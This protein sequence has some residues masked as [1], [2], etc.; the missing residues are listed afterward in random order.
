[1]R[2][3]GS[4]TLVAMVIDGLDLIMVEAYF[5]VSLASVAVV[6]AFDAVSGNVRWWR[7]RAVVAF[8]VARN[9]RWWGSQGVI[10]SGR[11]WRAG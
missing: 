6:V 1:M 11:K 9:I 2:F 3:V 10:E 8:N 7:G 5:E 4:G